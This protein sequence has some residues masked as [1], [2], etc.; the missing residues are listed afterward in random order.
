MKNNRSIRWLI[1]ALSLLFVCL[2]FSPC[3]SAADYV[4]PKQDLLPGSDM[5]V[6]LW[7][8]AGTFEKVK[9]VTLIGDTL[10]VSGT[11]RGI[12]AINIVDGA[13][14]WKRT[15]KF[16]VEQAP[17]VKGNVIYLVEGGQFVILDRNSGKERSRARVRL[18]IATPILPSEPYWVIGATN[19]RIYGII[20]ETGIHAWRITLD[21]GITQGVWDGRNSA[22]FLTTRGTLYAAST[23]YGTL[24]WKHKLPKP[25]CSSFTLSA[26]MLYVGCQDYYLHAINALSGEESWSLSLGAAVIGKPVVAGENIYVSTEDRVLH[27][28]NRRS[29]QAVW[30]IPNA[31]RLL[32][33]A[34]KYA[35]ILRK[36]AKENSI[37]IVELATG[38]AISEV[39][40]ARYTHFAGLPE[41]GILY[42]VAANG[43]VHAIAE[44]EVAEQIRKA[45]RLA[46]AQEAKA[47]SAP[48][49]ATTEAP[50]ASEGTTDAEEAVRVV[51]KGFVEASKTGDVEEVVKYLAPESAKF[52]R[53]MMGGSGEVSVDVML[54]EGTLTIP[55]VEITGDEAKVTTKLEADGETEMGMFILC[56]INNAWKIDMIKSGAAEEGVSEE[57]MRQMMEGVLKMMEEMSKGL[58]DTG[59][60]F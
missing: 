18:G 23:I 24:D 25:H 41:S 44:R 36:N 13:G 8:H 20:P 51:V 6:R 43:D 39:S 52:M 59:E 12:E 29:R 35:T 22:Y 40:A 42:A 49:G 30:A 11:P 28:I 7:I 48:A 58:E 55:S 15:G 53:A 38:E 21:S 56:R 14:R 37:G 33:A 19:E 9:H 17:A 4:R 46:A 57:E 27:A 45:M 50:P 16:L 47:P 1:A 10:Y 5:L 26:N 32:T 34:G 3:V 31:D 60:D 2:V 54:Q